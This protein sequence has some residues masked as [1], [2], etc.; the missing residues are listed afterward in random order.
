[1]RRIKNTGPEKLVLPNMG[2]RDVDWIDDA[3]LPAGSSLPRHRYFF[4]HSFAVNGNNINTIGRT[5]Y[6]QSIAAAVR[7][8]HI[9]GVQFHPEKSHKFG[10]ELLNAFG[11]QVMSEVAH[12]L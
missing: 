3:L 5:F 7:K 11:N 12:E 8:D 4:V 10:L 2:W 9:F 1:M 6:G